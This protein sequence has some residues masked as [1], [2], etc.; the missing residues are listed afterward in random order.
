MA[1]AHMPAPCPAPPHTGTKSTGCL[2]GSPQQR[3]I[4]SS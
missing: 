4:S 2:C 3:R 1:G